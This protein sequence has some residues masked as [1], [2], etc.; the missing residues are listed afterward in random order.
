M[1]VYSVH[2]HT[3]T[4]AHTLNKPRIPHNPESMP[5]LPGWSSR[6]P[7]F[8][9]KL[10]TTH[11][12]QYNYLFNNKESNCWRQ[13]RWATAF[14]A[15]NSV[16]V[17]KTLKIDYHTTQKSPSWVYA[18]KNWTQNIIEKFLHL[19]S[20]QHY[21]KSNLSEVLISQP[22][23]KELTYSNIR[24]TLREINSHKKTEDSTYRKYLRES[25]S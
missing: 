1:H 12:L 18:K 22:P 20:Q 11:I 21:S 14:A 7:S 10:Y 4:H 24:Q 19:C 6:P 3:C 8:W 2:I 23:R 17:L 16:W 13:Q 9:W 15:E 5:A 25:K